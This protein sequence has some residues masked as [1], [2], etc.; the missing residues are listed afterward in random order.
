M[1]SRLPSADALPV[2]DSDDQARSDALA[3][4]MHQAIEQAGGWI[5]FDEWMH[6][7]LYTPGLGY[8]SG[9]RSPLGA[10]GDFVT[11]P[12]LSPLFGQAVAAQ[13]AQWLR[14]IAPQGP[15]RI[16][17]FGA[18]SGALAASV[19]PALAEAETPVQ[20]Y[21]VLEVSGL[22]RTQ[23][24]HTLAERA[25]DWCERVCW[26]DALPQSF[27]GVILANEVIDALPVRLFERT[28]KGWEELGVA[29]GSEMRVSRAPRARRPDRPLPEG[30]PDPA[31]FPCGY[32]L[33]MAEQ[34]R[35]WMGSL[36]NTLHCG[37]VLLIDYGFPARELFHAQRTGGTLM[38]HFRHRAHTDLLARPGLQDLTA[39]VDFSALAHSGE[40]AGLHLAGYT[41]QARFL[42]NC[43]I[44]EQARPL[45][46][47]SAR[48]PD[49]IRAMGA[50]QTLLS[51]AEM[52]ELFKVMA[53]T[54]GIA[55][56]DQPW[57]GFA[58][59]D[60]SDMLMAQDPQP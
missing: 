56:T 42:L 51:E 32:R 43:G 47:Q 29:L 57:L 6:R 7:A 13:A 5:A 22:L 39:H 37:A 24:A 30:L 54:R 11:A 44:L 2:P 16:L 19:L 4:Q 21:A 33:E 17:E 35:A 12:E 27:T 18:G 26:L 9:P 48:D 3:G 53:F 49:A 20:E 38:A 58:R 50:L 8:Y 45:A 14:A 10:Q 60:R 46:A 52:G 34:A 31:P 40:Q 1:R 23:Q 41:S 59:G 25:P 36:G 28:D 55:A 15:W